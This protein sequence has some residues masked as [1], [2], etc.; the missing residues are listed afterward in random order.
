M[1]QFHTFI[2]RAVVVLAGSAIL[3]SCGWMTDNAL[4]GDNGLV[5]D[6]SQDYEQ[7]VTIPRLEVPE[8][9]DDEAIRDILII[10]DVGTVASRS[11]EEFEVPRPD[12]FYAESGNEIVS[13]AREGLEKYIV[14]D[15]PVREVWQKVG[16]FWSY[17]EVD[18]EL[19]NPAQGVMETAWIQEKSEEP[20]FFSSLLSKATFQDV[21]S[22]HRDKLRVLLARA[23]N[24]GRT[25]IKMQHLRVSDAEDAS[26]PD[27]SAQS[28]NVSYKSE[29]MYELLH[30][31][32]RTTST[33]TAKSLISRQNSGRGTALL[34]RDSNGNPVLKLATGIDN[35]WQWVDTAM[36]AAKVDVGSSD[37]DIGKYYITYTT[38]TPFNEENEG[39]F[40]GFIDWLHGDREDISISTDFLEDAIGIESDEE[41]AADKIR[42]S[43]SDVEEVDPDDLSKKEGYKIWLGGKAIYVFETS[44]SDF[45]EN[46]ETGELEHTGHYQIRLSRR[47]SGV[48]VSVLTDESKEASAIVAEE[49]LWNIKDNLP[50]G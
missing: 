9:L 48:Y 19:S 31:L 33:T 41:D 16:D 15:E 50:Q 49:I 18:I 10:P 1:K 28:R 43:Q 23:D 40:W 46:Q 38:S 26:Q 39:G 6:R 42:Y 3:S 22:P 35:A 45:V 30:Y 36:A 20:G 7:A 13:L 12:F 37:K 47:R 2:T 8:H 21:K 32:S 25:A 4:I 27:W 34:G 44:K 17:N 5:R 29:M 14:V 11:E 24:E